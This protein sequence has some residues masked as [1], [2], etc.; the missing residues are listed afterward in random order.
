MC[1][2]EKPKYTAS[3]PLTLLTAIYQPGMFYLFTKTIIPAIVPK[4]ANT[5]AAILIQL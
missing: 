5:N 1:N 4:I 2:I 3:L